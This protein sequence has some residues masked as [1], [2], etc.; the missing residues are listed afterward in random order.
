MSNTVHQKRLYSYIVIYY[1]E[2]YSKR[3]IPCYRVR[4]L[5]KHTSVILLLFE[6]SIYQNKATTVQKKT[7]SSVRHVERE[8]P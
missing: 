2:Y 3:H 4:E 7:N 8:V 5:C 6:L 1:Y